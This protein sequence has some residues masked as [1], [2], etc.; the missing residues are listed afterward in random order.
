MTDK[1]Q[2]EII[3]GLQIELDAIREDY[4]RLRKHHIAVESE[5]VKAQEELK[6]KK[7]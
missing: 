7:K 4:S 5:L 6:E 2:A 3:A 1:K